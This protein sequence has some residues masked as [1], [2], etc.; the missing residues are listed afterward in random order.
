MTLEDLAAYGVEHM[1]DDAIS[2]FLTTQGT[3]VLGL[4][5]DGAPALLPLSFGYDGDDTLY[6]TF[7]V[8]SGSEKAE[9]SERAETA[10]FLVY[11]ADTP[12]TWQSV[13]LTGRIEPVPEA[14]LDTA[15]DALENAWRPDL[16]ERA[17]AEVEVALYRFVVADW[18]GIKQTGLPPGFDE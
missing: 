12:F 1:D 14:E 2:A 17:M 16:F 3:G 8:G 15:S 18:S 7:V 6:F 13:R 4:P 5:S 10:S 11:R 9:L